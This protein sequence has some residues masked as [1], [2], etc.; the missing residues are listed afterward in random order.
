M[1]TNLADFEDHPFP[2]GTL[3]IES[4]VSPQFIIFNA[5]QKLVK[6]VDP[7]ALAAANAHILNI[8]HKIDRTIILYARWTNVE[9]PIEWLNALPP[10]AHA[11]PSHSSQAPTEAQCELK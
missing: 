10:P 9:P 6:I 2:Y 4:H 11:P 3:T 1:G 5:G 8:F 7:D